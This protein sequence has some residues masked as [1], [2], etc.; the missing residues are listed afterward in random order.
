MWHHQ[1]INRTVNLILFHY[2][3]FCLFIWCFQIVTCTANPH[4]MFPLWMKPLCSNGQNHIKTTCT[5]IL[6]DCLTQNFLLKFKPPY[7][8]IIC[9]FYWHKRNES[10][11]HGLI[12]YLGVFAYIFNFFFNAFYFYLLHKLKVYFFYQF[13]YNF[14]LN[15]WVFHS[16]IK[17]ISLHKNC[18]T[19][20]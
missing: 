6:V 10:D 7:K 15:K 18:C 17:R 13:I 3:F 20:F 8:E 5:H 1:F 12:L 16:I 19:F 9:C 2:Y 14:L 11:S 4:F